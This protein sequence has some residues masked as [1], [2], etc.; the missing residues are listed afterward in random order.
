MFRILCLFFMVIC[1]LM[2]YFLDI[3][4]MSDSFSMGLSFCCFIIFSGLICWGESNIKMNRI[5]LF[6]VALAMLYFC[7]LRSV[8]V[9]CDVD[10]FARYFFAFVLIVFVNAS[11]AYL[12]YMAADIQLTDGKGKYISII[13]NCMRRFCFCCAGVSSL[14]AIGGAVYCA[15]VIGYFGSWEVLTNY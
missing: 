5:R 11:A 15:I 6:M 4:I 7:L 9:F 12:A 2:S 8:A 1:K 10:L 3:E 13:H 14:I